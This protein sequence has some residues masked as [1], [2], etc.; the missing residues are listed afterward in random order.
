MERDDNSFDSSDTFGTQS[1][2]QTGAQGGASGSG[3]GNAGY[4]VQGSSAGTSSD[5]GTGGDRFGS[6]SG[7]GSMERDLSRAADS[8]RDTAKDK[9]GQ[10]KDQARE[11]LGQAK[12]RVGELKVS[13]AD[14]LDAGADKLRQRAGTN[15][16]AGAGVDGS[17][18]SVATTQDPMAKA[19][20]RVA[21]GMK[22]SAD[23][24][25]NN[26]IDSMKISVEEQ[27]RTNPGR[28]ILIAAV[29]GY[30]LG[31]AFRR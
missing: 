5:A 28:S 13:L 19:G 29:A 18:T 9:L 25:R 10:A 11:K 8:A 1:T 6:T 21:G 30:L 3:F 26:D 14:R 31:K 22:A 15:T 20:D 2:G 23:W 24:L 16:L 4:G 12:E 7:A 17:S 27:V